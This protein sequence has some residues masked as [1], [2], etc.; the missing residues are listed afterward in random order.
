MKSVTLS[1]AVR[2]MCKNTDMK[3]WTPRDIRRTYKTLNLKH[4][5]NIGMLN[6]YQNHAR[7]DVAS[8]HYDKYDYIKEKR[9]VAEAW[10]KTLVNIL[11]GEQV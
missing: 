8:V 11:N 5:A 3:P 1:Q 2:K 7:T 9:I 10:N 4:D 6:I